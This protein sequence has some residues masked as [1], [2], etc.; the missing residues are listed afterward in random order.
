MAAIAGGAPRQVEAGQR[1]VDIVPGSHERHRSP[2]SA[3]CG[4]RWAPC[5]WFWWDFWPRAFTG[6]GGGSVPG[7]ATNNASLSDNIPTVRD[8][9]AERRRHGADPLRRD[10]GG[11]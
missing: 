11:K 8:V 6:M 3:G 1:A 9:K 4:S 2:A 10:R 7:I 5:C